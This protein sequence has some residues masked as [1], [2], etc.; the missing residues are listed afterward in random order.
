MKEIQRE[1]AREEERGLTLQEAKTALVQ[2]GKR[3][4][5]LTYTEIVNRLGSFDLDPDQLDEFFDHLSEQGVD[6]INERDDE[7]GELDEDEDNQEGEQEEERFDLN[8]LTMP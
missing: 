5:S 8:D 3:R 6:V 1:A 4:G 2:L 7:D